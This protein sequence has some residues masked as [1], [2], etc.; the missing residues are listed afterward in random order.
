MP[1]GPPSQALPTQLQ[2]LTY[3]MG[4]GRNTIPLL[5]SDLEIGGGGRRAHTTPLGKIRAIISQQ[6]WLQAHLL[7]NPPEPQVTSVS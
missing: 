2:A 5:S 6:Q 3:L 1:A 4:G 7:S